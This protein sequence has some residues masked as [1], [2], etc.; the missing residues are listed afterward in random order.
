MVCCAEKPAGNSD[1]GKKNTSDQKNPQALEQYA[2]GVPIPKLVF[3]DDVKAYMRDVLAAPIPAGYVLPEDIRSQTVYD[4]AVA[5]VNEHFPQYV[6]LENE[7]LLRAVK[8]N[9]EQYQS[10][11]LES[12]C[13]RE[14]FFPGSQPKSNK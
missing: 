1:S 9:P 12:K 10:L 14:M 8:D 3:A 5:K 6:G 7:K 4:K 2:L 13:V 11:I